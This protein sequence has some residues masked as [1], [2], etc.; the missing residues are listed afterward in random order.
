MKNP[1]FLLF[2][3]LIL[4]ACRQSAEN[5][6]TGTMHFPEEISL[7]SE[8]IRLDTAIFRYPYR[9]SIVDDMAVVMDL[10]NPDHYLHAFSYPGWQHIASFGRHG[11]APEE[12][13]SS[14]NIRF[15]S[16][17]SLWTIDS[18]KMEITRWRID[19]AK[20][21]ATREEAIPVDKQLIRALDFIPVES[22]F[23]VDD[24]MG[25]HRYHF[26]NKAGEYVASYGSIPTEQDYPDTSRPALAQGWRCFMGT[27]SK[28]M[29]ITATQL[30]E[31]IELYDEKGEI[32]K[33]LK[34]E[35]GDPQMNIR[36]GHSIPTGIMGFVD[37]QVT[38]NYIY[39]PFNGI[40]F[41]DKIEA[42]KRGE[43]LDDGCK[44]IYVFDL[45][46]KP[47]RKYML[48]RLVH[49]I[50]VDETQG[51][52]TATDINQDDPIVQFRL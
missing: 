38:E 39:A 48:D 22:G 35:Q 13:L 45:K 52:I 11:E 29:I 49:G 42:Y 24:Y 37:L 1:L 51:I 16:P 21:I 2:S 31:V 6:L 43:E 23:W 18:N 9:I 41:K 12:L 34:G 15:C 40:S 50:H 32:C 19:A 3:L 46:G 14:S 33:V 25:E 5:N 4:C 26:L 7:Q 27:N 36:E 8:V 28:G 47:V 17:D 44:T 20:H 30:G 10:H